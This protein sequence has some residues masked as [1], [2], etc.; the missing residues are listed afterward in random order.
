MMLIN[1][2]HLKLIAMK[3]S[4]IQSENVGEDLVKVYTN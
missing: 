1:F 3:W 4:F 2:C